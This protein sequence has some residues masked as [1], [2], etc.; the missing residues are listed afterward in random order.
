[1]QITI[2]LC[3]ADRLDRVRLDDRIDPRMMYEDDVWEEI[4]LLFER[5]LDEIKLP[6]VQRDLNR[7]GGS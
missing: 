4:V 1:M 7:L 2:C 5:L 3:N 6:G